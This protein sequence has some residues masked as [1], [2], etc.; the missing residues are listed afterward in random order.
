MSSSIQCVSYSLALACV[1]L[2]LLIRLIWFCFLSPV[3][4]VNWT[5]PTPVMT[6]HKPFNKILSQNRKFRSDRATWRG[7][8]KWIVG[9]IFPF[10][11]NKNLHLG[12][13]NQATLYTNVREP[14]DSGA[15]TF[16]SQTLRNS[17]LCK[18]WSRDHGK[19]TRQHRWKTKTLTI[20]DSYIG[21]L[22]THWP[23]S[24]ISTIDMYPTF[25]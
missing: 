2:P 4:N 18:R 13:R 19:R 6:A 24:W 8:S 22:H 5:P 9:N 7:R 21:S 20:K 14:S 25:S 23:L 12:F 1:K 16:L 17:Q 11:V 15:I 3:I 10:I